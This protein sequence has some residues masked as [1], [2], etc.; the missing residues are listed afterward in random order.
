MECHT[1]CL[2]S[3]KMKYIPMYIHSLPLAVSSFLPPSW[4]MYIFTTLAIPPPHRYLPLVKVE[5]SVMSMWSAALLPLVV[6]YTVR[7]GEVGTVCPAPSVHVSS[8]EELSVEQSMTATLLEP[9]GGRMSP[10]LVS[11]ST[12]LSEM[13]ALLGM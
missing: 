11:S 2:D 1:A 10:T 5:V 4:L 13:M 8:C 9:S 3:E 7:L 12:P 6:W